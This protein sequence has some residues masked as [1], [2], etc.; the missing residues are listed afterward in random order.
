MGTQADYAAQ[1][2]A[3]LA[4][5]EPEL[6]TSV[7]SV[8]RKIIDAVSEVAGSADVDR[9][10]LDYQFFIDTKTGDDLDDFVL[11]WGFTRFA[12]KRATG[13]V[14]FSR[15]TLADRDYPVPQSTQVTTATSP[16]ITFATVAPATLQKGSTS[17]DV[18]IQAVLGGEAS[19]L[20]AGTLTVLATPVNGVSAAVTNLS[21]TSGGTN[22][23][24]DADMI[25]RFKKTVFRSLAGTEDMFLGVALEDTTPDDPSD[26]TATQAVVLGASRRW[27]E[28]V[29]IAGD[30]TAVSTIPTANVRYVYNGTQFLG[31]DLD[32]GAILTPGVHYTFDTTVTPPRVV[33]IGSA[34]TPGDFYDLDFEY[35]SSASRNDPANGVTN[36]V[37]IWVNGVRAVE[38][39]EAVYFRSALLLN[40]TSGDPLNVS[41]F[42]RKDTAGT[43][44]T[45][46]NYF[47][48]L[49]YGPILSFPATL[50]RQGGGT[51]VLGTDYWV[52]HDDTAFGYSPTSRFGVE[53]LAASAPLDGYGY[54]L[55]GSNA[56]TYNALP[57]DVEARARRWSLVTTDARAHAA[58]AVYLRLN[59]AVM[60]DA[61]YDR[62][63]TT[64]DLQRALAVYLDGFGFGQV[65]QVSD[66]LQAAH[67]VQ[68]VD[69]VRFVTSAE[70]NNTDQYAIER[71]S[72]AGVRVSYVA[73]GSPARPTDLVLSDNEVPV[74]HSV[75]V[76]TRAQ[77]TFGSY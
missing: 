25:A 73:T 15:A 32:A 51:L 28:Q 56:Y 40:N 2:I 17:V 72:S 27:R 61:A 67:A 8:T 41:N 69:N 23:E 36:R 9:T 6:D 52:M 74:L 68:G 13:V 44:P 58:K 39:T 62:A 4:V 50:P 5:S 35:S 65:V 46:G 45:A 33:S 76:S 77:N 21:P 7:G 31:T 37:D 34:L 66:I 18:P 59:F 20:T 26:E 64:T 63:Q 47:L 12:A 70:P 22:A 30:G 10:L 1:M 14:R 54:S 48:P 29:Q 38:A 49:A 55:S 53:I 60:F 43:H 16:T 24:S 3:A 57:R 11:N 42:V 71:V 75:T 19:N